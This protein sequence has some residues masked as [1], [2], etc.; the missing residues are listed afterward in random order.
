MLDSEDK[1][2]QAVLD[3]YREA[4]AEFQT[5][6]VPPTMTGYWLMKKSQV[7]ADRT[8]AD[9]TV[10]LAWLMKQYEVNTPFER[11][12]DLQAYSGLD[13]KLEYAT[14]VL[15]RGVDVS[16]VYYTPSKSLISF[17]VVCCPNRFHPQI[18]CPLQSS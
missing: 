6:N 8:W 5:G 15:P 9:L 10:A 3:R 1:R 18:P 7:S 2:Q 14:D 16:W 13:T 12:D 4:A 11:S 17:S